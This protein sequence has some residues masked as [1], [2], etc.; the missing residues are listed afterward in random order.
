MK[1]EMDIIFIS[2]LPCSG[3]S[4][5]TKRLIEHLGRDHA[6]RLPMDHYFLDATH[7][8][9]FDQ[10]SMPV[11]QRDRL[12]WPLLLE[13][14]EQLSRG[15]AID[16]PRYD[17]EHH[18]RVSITSH[19]GRTCHI[20][21]VSLVFVD[22]LHPSLDST[23]KHIYVTPSWETRCRL[24]HI[25]SNEMPLPDKYE[26]ILRQVEE[27]PF[28]ESLSWLS[29]HCWK[30]V[31]NPISMDLNDFCRECEWDWTLEPGH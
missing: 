21:P 14:L 26:A 16:T 1:E 3:K 13:H 20:D 2:G 17:W 10:Q 23:H 8:E 18:R 9:H 6:A 25:R 24:I 30:R 7:P 15:Q 27:S 4:H 29:T 12:D 5:L 28:G 31:D 11:Y 22:G 19:V